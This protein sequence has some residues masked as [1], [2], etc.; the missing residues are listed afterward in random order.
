M[1]NKIKIRF[2]LFFRLVM[3]SFFL[4]LLITLL[5]TV[6][7]ITLARL[8][9]IDLSS[10]FSL[11]FVAFGIASIIIGTLGYVIAVPFVLRP[12][13][14]LVSATGDI[15]AGNFDTHIEY[16]GPPEFTKLVDSFNIMAR[17]L[18]N[19]EI[20]R[21]DFVRDVS[22]EF[23]TPLQ[24]IRGFAKLLKKDNLDSERRQEYLD[25]IIHESERLGQLTGNILLLSKIGGQEILTD[26][27]DFLLD[28]QLRRTV[29]LFES[30]FE[31]K[32]LHV[33]M[34]FED[35]ACTGSE[36]LLSQVWINIIGN[37]VKFNKDGG[38]IHI[39]VHR[40]HD[41]AVVSVAD[42]GCG[43][44]AEALHHIFDKFYQADASRNVEGNGLGL[45]IVKRIVEL[46]QGRIEVAS[47]PKHG[48]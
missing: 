33:S 22:H 15:A 3:M 42:T 26:C 18:R 35:V 34:D 39:S 20:L 11:P 21:N 14:K 8:E 7:M 29:L 4:L 38:D 19:I 25:I 30:A 37:A 9:L 13:N 1:R 23:K 44:R 5:L 16:N 41:A 45:T 24:S 36:E 40:E 28:E 27:G 2:S 46:H 17:E 48:T 31:K 10:R 47:V 12:I 43:I 6:I 32:H